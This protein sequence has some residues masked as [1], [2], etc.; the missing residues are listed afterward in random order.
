MR[1]C[2]RML[3]L[4]I[5]VSKLPISLSSLQGNE[6]H[7]AELWRWGHTDWPRLESPG[8]HLLRDLGHSASPSHPL[9]TRGHC[10][11]LPNE[12]FD[13]AISK[14]FPKLPGHKIHPESTPWNILQKTICFKSMCRKHENNI[15]AKH[16][17][18]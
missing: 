13:K 6:E 7:W 1:N 18:N 2:G 8:Q 12:D 4:Q 16:Q 15:T 5:D 11:V 9:L 17:R 10:H 3:Y 14:C